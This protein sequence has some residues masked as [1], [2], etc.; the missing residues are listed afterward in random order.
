MKTKGQVTIF[1]IIAIV[2]IAVVAIGLYMK[3]SS[4]K[5]AAE[6]EAAITASLPPD[7][8]EIRA[9]TADCV[10]YSFEDALVRV[11]LF[12]GYTEPK[13]DALFTGNDFVNY[14][15]KAKRKS[16]PSIA[17]IQNNVAD[18]VQLTI[19]VCSNIE[20]EGFELDYPEPKA[21]VEFLD[22]K[23]VASVEYKVLVKKGGL[24]YTLSEPFEVEA[25]VKAKRLIAAAEKV[26]AKIAEKPE[27]IPIDFMLTLG[28][29]IDVVPVDEKNVVYRLPDKGTSLASELG[30]MEFAFIFAANIL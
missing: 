15:Y 28:E 4:Q 2:V 25:P 18:Y 9:M 1:V 29:E 20:V 7:V 13:D 26:V 27:E 11:G 30:N 16:L 24:S 19:P 17:E 10:Q 3:S 21:S 12:G 8:A 23:A 22:T 5:T 14:A 6:R